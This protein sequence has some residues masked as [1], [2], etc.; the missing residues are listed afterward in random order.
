MSWSIRFR[1]DRNSNL[2]FWCTVGFSSFLFHVFLRI[3]GQAGRIYICVLLETCFEINDV[4]ISVSIGKKCENLY[5]PYLHY[6]CQHYVA[7]YSKYMGVSKNRGTP[8]YNGKPY[9]NGWFGGKT[10][11]FWK[12]PYQ[13]LPYW[14]LTY[15]LPKVDDFPFPFRWHM[16]PKKHWNS[17]STMFWM[18]FFSVKTLVL[19][20]A[21]NQEFQ[22]TILC[23]CSLTSRD[24]K[25]FWSHTFSFPTKRKKTDSEPPR[26]L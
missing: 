7:H 3:F 4:L 16:L 9:W 13:S 1:K 14:E 23:K 24:T 17:K 6:C 26:K 18:F 12:H 19:V 11:Y 22:G 15:P 21:H 25:R 10:P 2:K 5:R 20:R 8:V